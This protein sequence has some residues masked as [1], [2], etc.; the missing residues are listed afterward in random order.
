[1]HDDRCSLL[2][3]AGQELPSPALS[4]SSWPERFAETRTVDGNQRVEL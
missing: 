2:V 3:A 4:E 1:V